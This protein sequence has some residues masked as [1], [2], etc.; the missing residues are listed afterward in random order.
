M[1]KEG[2]ATGPDRFQYFR[3][4]PKLTEKNTCNNPGEPVADQK[5]YST[6]SF[7]MYYDFLLKKD[8]G[9]PEIAKARGEIFDA[10]GPEFA[11]RDGLRP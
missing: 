6:T 2:R 3:Y 1:D 8:A 11:C 7:V 9:K 10:G 4:P 5:T